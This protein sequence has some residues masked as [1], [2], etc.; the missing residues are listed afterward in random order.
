MNIIFSTQNFIL[1]IAGLINLAM[2]LFIFSRGANNKINFYFGLVT[3]F[4]FLWSTCLIIINFAFS[5]EISRFFGSLVYPVALM[6][7]ISLFYFTVYFPYESFKVKKIN[8]WFIN[9]SIFFYT[10]YCTLFYKL[11][12]P[13]VSLSP[14]VVIYY[15]AIS[16]TIFSIILAF[17]MLLAIRIIYKKYQVAEGVFRIQLMMVLISVVIGTA[18]GFYFNLI[19]MYYNNL[20]YNHLGPLFTLFINF[21]VFGFIVSS[22][23]KI[24]N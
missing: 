24:S 2:S 3:L 14:K 11:F 19:A 23:E 16:Y 6:V 22:K 17:L 9:F 10:I 12:V 21:V 1:L 8:K 20:A 13:K 5:Y 4:N 18:A 7:V 15:E